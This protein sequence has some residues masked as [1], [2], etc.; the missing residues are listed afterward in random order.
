MVLYYNRENYNIMMISLYYN[1]RNE[2][3]DG[4]YNDSL[5]R[6]RTIGGGLV[7]VGRG[8]LYSRLQQ[9]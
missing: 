4:T 8:A 3:L 7:C 5:S 6:G 2:L 1:V 9:N